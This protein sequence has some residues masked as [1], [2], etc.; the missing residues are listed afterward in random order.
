MNA[1]TSRAWL[2]L[3]AVLIVVMCAF[4]VY[5]P[6]AGAEDVRV[7]LSGDQEVPPVKTMGSGSGAITV[8]SDMA[9]SGSVTTKDVP[10]SAAHIHLGAAGKNGEV[11]I[12]LQ[13][14]GADTW[15]VPSG[16]KLTPAQYDA[17]KAG[18]LYINVHTKAHPG[19]EVRAQL[20]P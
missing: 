5:P 8:G 12:P 15:T 10:G 13:K 20:K 16:A 1:F 7:M 2:S 17:F 11:I 9:V 3:S 14:S 4:V 6:R 18:D 19:G